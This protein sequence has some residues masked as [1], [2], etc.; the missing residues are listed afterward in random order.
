MILI[1]FLSRWEEKRVMLSRM[2]KVNIL[3]GESFMVGSCEKKTKF[4]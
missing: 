2:K 1:L 3:N 4:G